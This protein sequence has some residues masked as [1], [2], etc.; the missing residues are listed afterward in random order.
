MTGTSYWCS[1]ESG[2]NDVAEGYSAEAGVAEACSALMRRKIARELFL[3]VVLI[4][5]ECL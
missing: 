3:G 5:R 1:D 4:E 2:H